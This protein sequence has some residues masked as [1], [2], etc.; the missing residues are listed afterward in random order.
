MLVT[1]KLITYT[2]EW[3]QGLRD[4]YPIGANPHNESFHEHL[5]QFQKLEDG[6]YRAPFVYE[7]ATLP[8]VF[9]GDLNFDHEIN[10]SKQDGKRKFDLD[11]PEFPEHN[12]G[13]Y[14][15]LGEDGE[16]KKRYLNCYGVVD[17]PEQLFELFP[18][19]DALENRYFCVSMVEMRRDE[20]EPNGGW[21][22]HKWGAYLGTRE[23]QFEYLYDETAENRSDG[24]AIDAVWVYHIYELVEGDMVHPVIVERQKWLRRQQ[25]NAA[26]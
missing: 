17:T 2:A 13:I 19:I 15:D 9:T 11:Y 1:P 21:R 5:D 10:R 18:I 25:G 26:E 22:W 3:L 7:H 4:Q 24:K 23:P 6:S 8:G 20:Q 16:P 14:D 12:A